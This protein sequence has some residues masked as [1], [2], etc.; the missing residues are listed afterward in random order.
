MNTASVNSPGTHWISA[1]YSL[2]ASWLPSYYFVI[3]LVVLGLI[4]NI[5]VCLAMLRGRRFKKHLSNFILFHL[6][7]T[8]IAYRLIVVPSQWAALF[9]PFRAK[10]TMLCTVAKTVRYTFNTAVFTSLVIIAFDR[11]QSITRPFQRLKHKP[12]FYRYLLSV[13]GYSLL[14]AV[15]QMYNAETLILNYTTSH[16]ENNVTLGPVVFY[17]CSAS[18]KKGLT[19]ITMATIYYILGF[20][21][22]LV[23]IIIAYSDIY[24]FLRR[25]RRNR[26]IN[27]AA[28]KSKGKAL[29]M[30]VLVV[31]GFVVCLGVPQLCDL[32][33]SFV[34]KGK[35]EIVLLSFVLEMSSSIINPLIYGFYTADFN[36]GLKCRR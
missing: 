34:F 4:A 36:Q 7:I 23:V 14:C 17:H 27:Q 12:K 31:L 35:A 21:V 32:T 6:S 19:A 1:R 9:Y 5:T 11:R 8:G 28:L 2:L 18:S 10:P 16:N 25:K 22:P 24:V 33:R 15:P 13:W 26:M 20:L 30:L 3:S 29:R